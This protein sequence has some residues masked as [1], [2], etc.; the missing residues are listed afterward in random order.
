MTGW[1]QA[2]FSG[3][4]LRFFLAICALVSVLAGFGF[5]HV[6][7]DQYKASR[8]AEKATVL[9]LVD[10][11]FA[12]YAL[13][14]SG[15]DDAALPV[16]ATFRAKTL[17]QFN[18]TR[19]D[20]ETLHLNMVGFPNREIRTKATDD[21]M[22]E[23]MRGFE[24]NGEDATVNDL[25]TIG[26]ESLLRTIK[27]SIAKSQSC[28]DC[29]N[30]YAPADRQ[31]RLGEVMGAFVIDAPAG[32]AIARF[33]AWAIALSGAVFLLSASL[34]TFGYAYHH[35]RLTAAAQIAQAANAANAAKSGFLATMSHEIRTPLNGVLGNATLLRVSELN[36]EQRELV[37]TIHASGDS[38]LTILNDILDISKIEAD[39]LELETVECD[40][41]S[42]ASQVGAFW[43]PQVQAKG[44]DWTL[45]VDA[46]CARIL[47]SDPTRIKQVLF[48][49]LSNAIKFTETGGI[50]L[51]IS[52]KPGNKDRIE[53]RF[54]VV[55]T[56]IGIS[57]EALPKLF[58]MFSQGDNTITRRFGGTGLGLAISKRLA[59]AMDGQTGMISEPGQGSTFWFTILTEV[60]QEESVSTTE[61][62]SEK[63]PR[64][65]DRSCDIL[66]AEDNPINQKLIRT[67]LLLLGHR[68]D[69]AADGLE[70]I[71]MLQ[72]KTYDLILM[73][74]QMPKL[75]GVSAARRIRAMP[76]ALKRTP[77]IALTANSMKGDREEYI[78]AGM[79][80]YV[81]KPIGLEALSAAIARVSTEDQDALQAAS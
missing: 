18:R 48:N 14:Q 51:N 55:D 21:H 11:F 63:E 34:L 36:D 81:A 59:E 31:W 3:K 66:V 5:K 72:E 38:L 40:L 49:I 4:A 23:A 19:H 58:G 80:D 30:Q 24:T 2:W 52:Q 69:I 64:Q 71:E 78:A 41:E 42:I 29:H 33:T 8:L 50:Q 35:R 12:N 43:A 22:R 65:H 74:V 44:L 45:S 26:G 10:A 20:G 53:T 76:G 61:N 79:D 9:S 54:E 15:S 39:Q 1:R 13:V 46:S 28:V 27:P 32:P 16:P 47:L 60:G 68:A 6:M 57:K 75:D 67:M 62:A 73:D 7:I 25:V 77:I 37:D 17:E 70:A 56:G